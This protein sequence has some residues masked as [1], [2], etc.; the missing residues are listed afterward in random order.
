LLADANKAMNVLGWNPKT[1]LKE[2]AELM[3]NSDLDKEKL[4]VRQKN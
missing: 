3:Y 2:L 1:S 4:N